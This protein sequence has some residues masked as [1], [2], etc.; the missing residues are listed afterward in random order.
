MPD[1]PALTAKPRKQRWCPETFHVAGA[2]RVV[3]Y[4]KTEA[5]SYEIAV[6]DR[7]RKAVCYEVRVSGPTGEL[8]GF[9]WNRSRASWDLN[10]S[11]TIRTRLRGYAL[12]WCCG[13]DRHK[14]I[15]E[16]AYTRRSA[17]ERLLEHHHKETEGAAPTQGVG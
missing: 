4:M 3:A 10:K 17:T 16:L 1:N 2:Y 14:T 13:A 6:G 12:H 15:T 9:V 8:I 7:K 11:R 5:Y